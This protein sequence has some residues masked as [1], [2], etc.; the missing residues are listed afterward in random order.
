M[1]N[2]FAKVVQKISTPKTQKPQKS[3]FETGV[4]MF[5]KAVPGG[6][7]V[8]NKRYAPGI[9]GKKDKKTGK[10]KKSFEIDS[11]PA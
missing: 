10:M 3:I 4:D 5:N 9:Y 1:P 8:G 6:V 7:K 2:S 11:S